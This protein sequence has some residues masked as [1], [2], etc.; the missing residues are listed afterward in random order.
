[1]CAL[2]FGEAF[3]VFGARFGGL[4]AP[5][6]GPGK[7]QFQTLHCNVLAGRSEERPTNK[8]PGKPNR[9]GAPVWERRSHTTSDS[10][11]PLICRKDVVNNT[12]EL[13]VPQGLNFKPG[14]FVA[15]FA[16]PPAS[17]L[18]G[19]A[20]P[21]GAEPEPETRRL[22]PRRSSAKRKRREL[23]GGLIGLGP[24]PP[25]GQTSRTPRCG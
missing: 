17:S 3:G 22:G 8:K 11:K 16:G 7:I 6:F 10:P 24:P 13:A 25:R 1:M 21:K 19:R 20:P 23:A 14:E 5:Y 2:C 12:V 18:P 15:T 9:K 4:F